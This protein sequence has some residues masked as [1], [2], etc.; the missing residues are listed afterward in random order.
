MKATTFYTTFLSAILVASITM[1]VP[2]IAANP[3]SALGADNN[4][5]E[6]IESRSSSTTVPTVT[7][8]DNAT[9]RVQVGGGNMTVQY[10]RFSP[11]TV[12]IDAGQNVTWYSPAKGIAEFHTVTFVLD[13]SLI[14]DIILPFEVS[15]GTEFKLVPPSNVGEPL[16]TQT[17]NG[18]TAVIAL[19]K[20][21]FNPSVIG[22][23]IN[24]TAYLNGTDIQVTL[25]G[26][27]KV[28]NSGIIQPQSA[29]EMFAG[30]G[31]GG[32]IPGSNETTSPSSSSSEPMQDL[33]MTSGKN[34][35]TTS[36]IEGQQPPGGAET[37]PPFPFV[38]EFTVTFEKPGTYDYFCAFH[39]WMNG[40]VIVRGEAGN[41]NQTGTSNTL[42]P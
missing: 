31:Q 15:N 1:A 38:K 33:N 39:P 42:T 17:P 25:N 28:V 27:E 41:N 26:T 36:S 8:G 23:D 18:T 5:T 7:A 34:S 10:Y 22:Q 29:F 11:Q 40:Q 16:T 14:S 6:N 35:T 37:G 20:L 21:T 2:L 24:N 9:T 12:E 32:P 19:N 30:E 3:I 4:S 13:K